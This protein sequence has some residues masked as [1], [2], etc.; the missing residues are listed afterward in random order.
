MI[1]NN[2]VRIKHQIRKKNELYLI[3]NNIRED[4]KDYDKKKDNK[5]KQLKNREKTN[6]K[7]RRKRILNIRLS[8]EIM[9]IS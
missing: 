6:I 4:S 7:K 2:K 5:K 3:L 8:K 1:V 9:S